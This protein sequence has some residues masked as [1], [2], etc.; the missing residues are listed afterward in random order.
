M[1]RRPHL[2][3]IAVAT[4][5][6]LAGCLGGQTGDG[7]GYA[8]GGSG[9]FS[10]GTG[11]VGAGAG[12]NGGNAGGVGGSGGTGVTGGT[13]GVG[14]SGGAGGSGGLDGGVVTTCHVGAVAQEDLACLECLAERCCD[15]CVAAQ[16]DAIEASCRNEGFDCVRA[17]HA[18]TAPTMPGVEPE[19]I[20]RDCAATCELGA[21]ADAL[22]R[23]VVD[24]DAVGAD[25]GLDGGSLE[26]DAGAGPPGT[27]CLFTCFPSPQ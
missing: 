1:P 15:A 21:E 16:T 22:L 10:G 24:L 13:G 6:C 4:A 18:Q 27:S 25:A 23:C 26:S 9:G 5:L 2:S 8:R 14:A 20:V 3:W 19:R 17:C 7:G 12:F 11:G